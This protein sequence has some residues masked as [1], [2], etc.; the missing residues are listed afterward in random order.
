MTILNKKYKNYYFFIGTEAELIKLLPVILK[1]NK[2]NIPFTIIA[3]GQNNIIKSELFSIIKPKSDTILLSQQEIKQTVFGYLVWFLMTTIKGTVRLR[4][5]L[6]R[7]KTL[8]IVHGDTVSTVMG[9]IVAKI[10]RVDIAHI[11]AGLRSFNYFH[12]FPEEIDRVITSHLA[13]YHFCPNNW[14]IKNLKLRKGIKINTY[15]NTLY[16]S[17]RF[18]IN[19][20]ENPFLLKQLKN[21]KFAIFVIHRQE[22]LFNNVFLKEII[23]EI[24]ETSKEIMCIFVLHRSTKHVLGKTHLLSLLKKNKNIFLTERLPYAEFMKLLRACEFIVTDGGS[25]QEESYYLGKPCLILRSKTERI[26]GIGKNVVLNNNTETIHSFIK[27]YKS[28]KRTIKSIEKSPSEII[29]NYLIN[30]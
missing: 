14:A 5:A 23:E 6:L 25:N 19:R 3:S 24:T 4:K 30:R 8:M 26:E 29:A 20:K 22:N 2:R 1:F 7:E 21:K 16:D 27:N 9:A 11:E 18:I 12:P 28:Y 15:Q 10:F 17:L 13:T